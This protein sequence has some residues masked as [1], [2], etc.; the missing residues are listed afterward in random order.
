MDFCSVTWSR[1][2]FCTGHSTKGSM[3]M[4]MALLSYSTEVQ[5]TDGA[6]RFGYGFCLCGSVRRF[7]FERRFWTVRFAVRTVPEIKPLP[8]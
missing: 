6:V 1:P 3:A 8:L 2:F 4:T 7:G 5:E